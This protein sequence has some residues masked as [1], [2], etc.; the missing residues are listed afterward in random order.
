MNLTWLL[1]SFKGRIQRL[2]FW[3]SSLVVGV[4]VAMLTSTFQFIAQSY[5]MGE[6][7]PESNEFEPTGPLSIA[8]FVIAVANMWINFALSIKR[9][10]DRD[11]T[12]WWLATLYLV[13]ILAI[14]L[15]VV[16]LTQPEGQ[17]EPW[18]SAGVIVVIAA[19]VL[20]FWLFIEIGFL[21]GTQA[22]N[23]YGLDPLGQT[24]A[25]ANL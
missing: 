12:G 6:I 20:M 2:Y 24:K 3:V 7:N 8:M 22:P 17:R 18:N 9:L 15:G 11:R 4:V 5:G 16:T 21:K 23:R 25:D 10:H 1:F 14:V 13:I 19:V